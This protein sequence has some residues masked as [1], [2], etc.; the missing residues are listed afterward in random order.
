MFGVRRTSSKA[1]GGVD[2]VD[3]RLCESPSSWALERNETDKQQQNVNLG[4]NQ[5]IN[6]KK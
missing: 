3:G 4:I 1:G 6:S 2:D 5:H